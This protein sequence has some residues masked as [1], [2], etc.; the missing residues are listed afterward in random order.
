MSLSGFCLQKSQVSN[1]L[2]PVDDDLVVVL[3]LLFGLETLTFRAN[4][5][6]NCYYSV[7]QAVAHGLICWRSA[8]I[9][10]S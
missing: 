8:R 4:L 5:G 2:V 1:V 3:M 9:E 10:Y 6:G 7:D